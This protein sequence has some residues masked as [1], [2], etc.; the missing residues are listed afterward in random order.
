MA[1]QCRSEDPIPYAPPT[2]PEPDDAQQVIDRA[3]ELLA[4]RLR[5]PGQIINTPATTKQFLTLELAAEKSERFCILWLD[6]RHRMI[7]FETM[8]NGTI[9]GANVYP[10]ELVRRA[11]ELNAAAA[12]L[13]HNHPSGTPDPSAADKAITARV[14]D[15]FQLIGVRLIDHVVIGGEEAISF[16]EKGLI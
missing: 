7:R 9:D 12:I 2:V 8:F 5:R 16:A 10:R 13:A 3:L 11:L 1:E 14:R 4:G 6:N 15:A